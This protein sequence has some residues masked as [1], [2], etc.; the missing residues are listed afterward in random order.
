MTTPIDH[1]E[2]REAV[3][4]V[5]NAALALLDDPL[6]LVVRDPRYLDADQTEDKVRARAVLVDGKVR[7]TA[8]LQ[9]IPPTWDLEALFIFG[10]EGLGGADADR[11]ARVS[12]LRKAASA[13]IAA[14]PRLGGVVTYASVRDFEPE[15]LKTPGVDISTLNS[16]TIAVEFVSLTQTG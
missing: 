15:D 4:S 12:A 13:A 3:E 1:D 2:A 8:F 9:G 10:V 14:N 16:L 11:W 5:I 7:E 6:E